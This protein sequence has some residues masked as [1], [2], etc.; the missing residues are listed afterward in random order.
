MKG[1]GLG[2]YWVNE[3]IK[4]HGGKININNKKNLNGTEFIIELPI[5]KIDKKALKD[6][7][8]YG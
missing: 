3:I 8:S 2:L 6:K 5:Y 7:N 1:T 4:V